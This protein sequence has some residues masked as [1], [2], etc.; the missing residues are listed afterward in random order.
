MF[1]DFEKSMMENDGITKGDFYTLIHET[2]DE[3]C[4]YMTKADFARWIDKSRI[5][6]RLKTLIVDQFDEQDFKEQPGAGGYFDRV[7]NVIKFRDKSE[8]TRR[9][10]DHE[11]MHLIS[12]D[13]R[14]PTFLNE[15]L[16]EYISRAVKGEV[17]I[18]GSYEFNVR[19]VKFLHFILG[20]SLIKNYLSGVTEDFR[21]YFSTFLT[22]DGEESTNEYFRFMD[23]LEE[24]HENAYSIR[25]GQKPTP[26]R[27]ERA[28]QAVYKINEYLLQMTKAYIAKDI[29]S[30]DYI[31]DGKLDMSYFTERIK[32]LRKFIQ[33][34]GRY[35]YYDNNIM[36][37]S[38]TNGL[39]KEIGNA[40]ANEFLFDSPDKEKIG[41]M[42]A[43]K[44]S[45]GEDLSKDLK[46]D[47]PDF[48]MRLAE[49][50]LKNYSENRDINNLPRLLSEL[51]IIFE[52][53]G[54]TELQKEAIIGEKLFK[55][56][57]DGVDFSVVRNNIGKVMPILAKV[58]E[59]KR[60]N[61]AH[62]RTT[63]YLKLSPREYIQKTDN[64]FY[65]ITIVNGEMKKQRVD[66]T[67][68]A[69]PQSEI[70]R[71]FKAED[72]LKA[73]KD[74]IAYRTSGGGKVLVSRNLS[75]SFTS[76]VI[77]SSKE[78]LDSMDAFMEDLYTEAMV[79]PIR[80][81]IKNGKYRYIMHDAEDPY[82]IKGLKYSTDIDKR[83]RELKIDDFDKDLKGYLSAIPKEKREV[84]AQTLISELLDK[85]YGKL[86]E[87][88]DSAKKKLEEIIYRRY[89]MS[90]KIEKL[91]DDARK[92][93]EDLNKFRRERVEKQSQ[94]AM[95][96]VPE[97]K[98]TV[99]KVVMEQRR[100]D[101]EKDNN[102]KVVRDFYLGISNY[103]I[104]KEPIR[105]EEESKPESRRIIDE[106]L[107]PALGYVGPIA[108]TFT[109]TIDYEKYSMGLK[110]ALD[111]VSPSERE[112]A[113]NTL[114]SK[115]FSTYYGMDTLSERKPKI[116]EEMK[117]AIRKNVFDGEELDKDLMARSQ[118]E[119]RGIVQEEFKTAQH[120][121]A[122]CVMND[123]AGVAF[124]TA[125]KIA[126]NKD[127]P[128]DVKVLTIK[129]ILKAAIDEKNP[130]YATTKSVL[131]ADSKLAQKDDKEQSTEETK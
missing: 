23:A 24:Y 15:G 38:I 115:T 57:P 122:V 47:N 97:D 116:L 13:S 29:H 110:E 65:H 91:D 20:D 98:R 56:I 9:V 60:I 80:E 119:L 109:R 48:I 52:K 105:V 94:Y 7:K 124:F 34:T 45:K 30:L 10:S 95:V 113:F 6:D 11:N 86:P 125:S 68:F 112:N 78:K 83:S 63:E 99:Y 93:V 131:E 55:S 1:R 111:K 118:E 25:E 130:C 121:S 74:A 36:V 128:E 89:T 96:E 49:N 67:E 82:F 42:L 33:G 51:E 41:K 2:Y 54:A 72:V 114:M 46:M 8:S 31:K 61:D 103:V 39:E 84:V 71:T 28:K 76:K 66:T 5:S 123:A 27:D 108:A 32:A 100:K 12:S 73:G 120:S 129:E 44:I 18:N 117:G 14:F 58:T 102:K 43:E 37:F 16:T 64:E 59:E 4:K 92:L 107:R 79:E 19:T 26:E 53:T 17:D 126:N 21:K 127:I 40:L 70:S 35:Q 90:R 69:L 50:R 62:T 3:I 75:E 101:R 106:A 85:T 104:E 81:Q 87:D 88:A 22:P 77:V